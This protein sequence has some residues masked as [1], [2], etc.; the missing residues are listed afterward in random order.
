[1]V[2]ECNNCVFANATPVA[3]PCPMW[4]ECLENDR[5]L[6]KPSGFAK[7]VERIKKWFKR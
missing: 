2:K 6:F 3:P 5:N 7:A 1:M 4:Q